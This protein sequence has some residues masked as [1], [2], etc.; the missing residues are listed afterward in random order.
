MA[1]AKAPPASR[2]YRDKLNQLRKLAAVCDER[3]TRSVLAKALRPC[4]HSSTACVLQALLKW[5]L[6]LSIKRSLEETGKE[7]GKYSSVRGI[8]DKGVQDIQTVKNAPLSEYSKVWTF[9]ICLVTYTT[10]VITW[11][12]ELA[13]ATLAALRIVAVARWCRQEVE[14][15]H[16][17]CCS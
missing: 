8:I 3:R 11:A 12:S 5:P 9:P 15:G 13:G 2:A 10:M 4:H 1:S 6:Q 7:L 14:V 17:V 16:V